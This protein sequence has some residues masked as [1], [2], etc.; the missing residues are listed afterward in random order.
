VARA[1][2]RKIFSWT[3]V[4]APWAKTGLAPEEG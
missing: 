3:I 1:V 2:E 4:Q